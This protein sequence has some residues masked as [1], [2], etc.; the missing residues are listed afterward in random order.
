MEAGYND[1]EFLV[2][3]VTVHLRPDLVLS[4]DPGILKLFCLQL[5]GGVGSGSPMGNTQMRIGKDEGELWQI[6]M[7]QARWPRRTT[8][9]WKR[10]ACVHLKRFS[11][12]SC[13]CQNCCSLFGCGG[14]ALNLPPCMSVLASQYRTRKNY[15]NPNYMSPR[16]L[17]KV[18]LSL[19][20]MV[21]L[22]ERLRRA[23]PYCFQ[24]CCTNWCLF[25][26]AVTAKDAPVCNDT[27]LEH[28]IHIIQREL[29][30]KMKADTGLY[31][32]YCV[33]CSGRCR[34]H[35]S[36]VLASHYAL[37]HPFVLSASPQA[38]GCPLPN[39]SQ[40]GY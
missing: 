9:T 3:F 7:K 37:R 15:K 39:A 19:L 25:L 40:Q 13:L 18:L 33:L 14:I 30:L 38:L 8:S 24:A 23:P 20:I 10:A 6:T 28:F 16:V 35:P 26:T 2:D 34:L 36:W 4:D 11:W 31:S 32:C 22:I 5:T 27:A 21:S 12:A 1:A 29:A 17:D